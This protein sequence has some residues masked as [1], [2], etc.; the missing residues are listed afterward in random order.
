MTKH[1]HR[2]ECGADREEQELFPSRELCHM[3]PEEERSQRDG[4]QSSRKT[5][6]G[7]IELDHD[8]EKPDAHQERADH[9]LR[10]CPG[11][12]FGPVH[13]TLFD[14][15]TRQ[16]QHLECFFERRCLVVRDLECERFVSAEREHFAFF[17]DA[18]DLDF[19]IHHRFR[20]VTTPAAAFGRG[21][22]LGAHVRQVLFADGG[23]LF[24]V[25]AA[26]NGSRGADGAARRD[27]DVFTRERDQGTGGNR[28]WV[29][30]GHGSDRRFDDGITDEHRGVDASAEGVDVEENHPFHLR[31][32]FDDA[33]YKRRHPEIDRAFDGHAEH[34][35][36]LGQRR[37]KFFGF[38][39]SENVSTDT[40]TEHHRPDGSRL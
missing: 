21:A 18:F 34:N 32:L 22:H 28:A 27:D 9:R 8:P 15:G 23:G 26:S 30:E 6:A 37:L 12:D 1:L 2:E 7:L 39:E 19:A 24:A 36:R 35:H 4:A 17:D 20:H 10:D 16:V 25:A 38:L 13:L 29:D 40:E 3:M 31:R 5:P 11:D 14:F 33:R